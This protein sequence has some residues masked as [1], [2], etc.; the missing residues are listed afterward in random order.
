MTWANQLPS[1]CRWQYL[2]TLITLYSCLIHM[3]H[4]KPSQILGPS[5]QKKYKLSSFNML[6]CVAWKCL[7]SNHWKR[8]RVGVALGSF[9]F[10]SGAVVRG[11]DVA[12][13]RSRFKSGKLHDSSLRQLAA[14]ETWSLSP[15]DF[16]CWS[17]TGLTYLALGPW[18]TGTIWAMLTL[19]RGKCVIQSVIVRINSHVY[20]LSPQMGIPVIL[21]LI[22]CASWQPSGN[23][24]PSA[25]KT[26]N[27]K[28]LLLP[29]SLYIGTWFPSN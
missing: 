20:Q 9:C 14:S 28:A 22:V 15:W 17:I 7:P 18:W 11:E 12:L 1:F 10:I 13:V 27:I 6:R 5:I 24:G 21:N 16:I 23:Q 3:N 2:L 26:P 29:K 25:I 19:T 8:R 4:I